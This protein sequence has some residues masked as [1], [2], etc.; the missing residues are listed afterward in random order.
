MRGE[1]GRRCGGSDA[2]REPGR[3]LC[4]LVGEALRSAMAGLRAVPL[5]SGRGGVTGDRLSLSL[6]LANR[7]RTHARRPHNPLH[8]GMLKR[9]AC[10]M[11][12]KWAD[13]QDQDLDDMSYLVVHVWQ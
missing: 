3:F 1:P 9:N 2:R 4:Q 12:E 13:K 5:F 11:H 7:P 10:E 8:I 6:P